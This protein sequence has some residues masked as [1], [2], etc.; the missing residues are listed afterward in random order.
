MSLTRIVDTDDDLT[1]LT[2]TVHTNAWLQ[3][4]N[5]SI[6][7]R[8]SRA[9]ITLTGAQNNLSISEADLVIFNNASLLTVQGIAAPASPAKPG[10]RLICVSTGAGQVDF[11]PQNAGSTAANRLINFATVGNTS[12]AAGAGVAIFVYD[13]ANSRWRL[14]HHEQGD[15]ITPTFAAGDYT[16]SGAM[17]WTLQSGDV[18]Q[19]EFYLKGRQLYVAL[20]LTTTTVGGT[21]G[22][23]LLVKI[24]NG[25]TQATTT[26]NYLTAAFAKD[27]GTRVSAL[28]IPGVS[29]STT[30]GIVR[31]DAAAWTAS[32]NL[33]DVDGIAI[34]RVD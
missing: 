24:P 34:C 18:L 27:N 25:Y 13:D 4:I 23:T 1:G 12:L 2:G 30:I 20:T 32:T 26:K 28:L 3:T 11:A 31:L 16:G 22:S 15:W 17:T 8:W 7:A 29:S 10:K 6:D 9:T 33:T 21:P 14:V 19:Y 5:D